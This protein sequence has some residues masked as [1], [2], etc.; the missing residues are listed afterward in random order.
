MLPRAP[1]GVN[2]AQENRWRGTI[3]LSNLWADLP[4]KD[5]VEIYFRDVGDL[6]LYV[7]VSYV[8]ICP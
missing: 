7:C 5:V 8:F 2:V 3:F 1:G 4:Q 6:S